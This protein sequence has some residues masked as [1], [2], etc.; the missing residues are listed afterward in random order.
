VCI[1]PLSLAER[2][3]SFWQRFDIFW[4]L[5]MASMAIK[6]KELWDV[7]LSKFTF[8]LETPP[9]RDL[10]IDHCYWRGGGDEVQMKILSAKTI[11]VRR[12]LREKNSCTESSLEKI[13]L[14]TKK[15]FLHAREMLTKKIRTARE[16]PILHNFSN[17]P[18]FSCDWSDDNNN[19]KN[20]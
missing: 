17:G 6:M 11:H 7:K 15:I 1:I 19:N 3:T 4:Q 14:H 13:F 8:T 18:S 10:V 2:F 9:L 20:N 16:F 5:F 12:K